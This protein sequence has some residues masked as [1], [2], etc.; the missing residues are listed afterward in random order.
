MSKKEITIR[1]FITIILVII[2]LLPIIDK[3]KSFY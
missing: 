3:L 2:T 1:I